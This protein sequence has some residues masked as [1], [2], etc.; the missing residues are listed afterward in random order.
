MTMIRRLLAIAL[1]A[2]AAGCGGHKTDTTTS[3]TSTTATT[4]PAVSAAAATVAPA[5]G[6]AM[7]GS[8]A[9]GSTT[10]SGQPPGFAVESDAQAHC[11][12]DQVVWLNTKSHVYHEKGALY[13]GHTKAGAYVCRKEADA[14]GDHDA[15]NGK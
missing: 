2:A 13:Y 12:G 9:G 14:A 1:L 15:K 6:G 4:A 11:V 7:N 10:G 3:T 5:A 8:A